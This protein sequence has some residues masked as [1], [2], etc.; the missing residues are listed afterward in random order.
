MSRAPYFTISTEYYAHHQHCNILHASSPRLPFSPTTDTFSFLAHSPIFPSLFSIWKVRPHSLL[1]C[2][3][4]A[5]SRRLIMKSSTIAAAA[6]AALA[7]AQTT[8]KMGN[9]AITENNPTM[10]AYMASLPSGTG[11]Q[12]TIEGVSNANGT[13]VEWNV[14]FFQFPG[15]S[16]A[17]FRKLETALKSS[18]K[19]RLTNVHPQ[20]T[21]STTDKYRQVVHAPQPQASST[22][23]TAV[24]HQPATPFNQRPGNQPIPPSPLSSSY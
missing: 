22:P 16:K 12:G 23:T 1:D 24:H 14:N 11:V 10:V 17:P 18:D 4:R 2:C 21:P 8:G 7:T 15:A 3:V 5:D 19:A 9:A 6:S 20:S 13:G